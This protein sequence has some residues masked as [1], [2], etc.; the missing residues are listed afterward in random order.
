M[1]MMQ[2]WKP[3]VDHSL[4]CALGFSI[5]YDLESHLSSFDLHM[6]MHEIEE[7]LKTSIVLFMEVQP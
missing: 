7:K 2:V 4:S 1:V 6:K 3:M 5:L